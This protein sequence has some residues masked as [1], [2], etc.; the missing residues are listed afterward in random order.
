VPSLNSVRFF[1]KIL[2][3]FGEIFQLFFGRKVIWLIDRVVGFACCIQVLGRIGGLNFKRGRLKR[4]CGFGVAL[5]RSFLCLFFL[6]YKDC[7]CAAAFFVVKSRL[8]DR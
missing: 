1:G 6:F 4:G 2:P 8:K 5:L 7:R 3:F